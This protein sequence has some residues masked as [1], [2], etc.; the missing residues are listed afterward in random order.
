MSCVSP[1]GPLSPPS[2]PPAVLPAALGAGLLLV[3]LDLW[4]LVRSGARS[5]W[6]EPALVVALGLGCGVLGLG[7]L[8]WALARLLRRRGWEPEDALGL[9]AGLLGGT[10]LALVV[11]SVRA[12]YLDGWPLRLGLVAL[13]LLGGLGG[14]VRSWVGPGLCFGALGLAVRHLAPAVGAPPAAPAA[15]PPDSPHVVLITLDTFR[16]DHLGA[17]GGAWHA[18]PT[19][20]LDALAAEGLLYTEGQAPVALTLPSHTTMLTGEEPVDH[21]LLKNGDRPVGSLRTVAHDL[22]EAGFR[23]GAFVTSF[24]LRADAGLAEGFERYQDRGSAWD[25]A[26]DGHLADGLRR[27][28]DLGARPNQRPGSGAVLQALHWVAE[29]ERPAFVWVHLYD[30]HAPYLPPEALLSSFDSEDPQAPGNPVALKELARSMASRG[31]RPPVATDLRGAIARYAAE[32]TLV[33]QLVG[34]LLAGLPA[35]TRVVVAADHGESLM[36]HG[37]IL[38]HGAFVY[39]S[40][41]RV[42][43]IVRAPGLLEGGQRFD[44]PVGLARVAPTLRVLGGL[45][46]GFTG[47]LVREVEDP[48]LWMFAPGQSSRFSLNIAPA[49]RVGLRRGPEKYILNDRA[50]LE[51]FDLATDPG[52][53]RDLGEAAPGFQEALGITHARMERHKDLSASGPTA[54]REAVEALRA[55]GYVE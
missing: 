2:R 47:A 14:W 4:Q 22:R 24:V 53:T 12:D 1:G 18:P 37:E 52:E 54:D 36:E 41:I 5:A 46:R 7:G 19:P 38:N 33:D 3:A 21:G 32:I 23:T 42:P 31:L 34:E 27:L 51:A 35:D 20:N 10:W 11:A 17:I 48:E 49:W 29:S 13:I 9:A 8:A 45:E 26:L 16:A 15:P 43:I 50:G 40:T 44:A 39:Q 6:Q 30:A 55:L 25:H 28:L